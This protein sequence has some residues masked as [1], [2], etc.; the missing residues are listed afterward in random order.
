MVFSG[1]F[2]SFMIS[3]CFPY[4]VEENNHF[5][6]KI[7]LTDAQGNLMIADTKEEKF[8]YLLKNT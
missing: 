5:F 7:I 2:S 4:V 3:K 1:S 6:Y 8:E